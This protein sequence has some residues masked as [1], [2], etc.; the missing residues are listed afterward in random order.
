MAY[1]TTHG[2]GDILVVSTFWELQMKMLSTFTHRCVDTL[3]IVFFFKET[4]KL[5][6]SMAVSLYLPTGEVQGSGFSTLSRAFGADAGA[7]LL[8]VVSTRFYQ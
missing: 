6:P 8:R 5:L 1:L 3:S 4:P 7:P 2:S